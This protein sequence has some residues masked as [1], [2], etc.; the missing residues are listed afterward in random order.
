MRKI[1]GGARFRTATAQLLASSGKSQA[2]KA[3]WYMQLYRTKDDEY[4]L[5][6]SNPSG[7]RRFTEPI[8][9]RDAMELYTTLSV[10]YASVGVGRSTS[11]MVKEGVTSSTAK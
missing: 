2:K 5:R 3:H 1:E 9:Q 6:H 11:G 8:S 10:K 7:T 4:F